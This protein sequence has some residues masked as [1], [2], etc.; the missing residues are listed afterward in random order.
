M[1]EKPFIMLSEPQAM[2]RK[3]V[4]THIVLPAFIGG[5]FL[6]MVS[7]PGVTMLFALS[8]NRDIPSYEEISDPV[9]INRTKDL[10][11]V[12][13]FLARHP[14]PRIHVDR[15]SGFAVSY[16]VMKCEFKKQPCDNNPSTVDPYIALKVRLDDNGYP[17]STVLWCVDG[18]GNAHFD[19]IENDFFW[20]N[21]I[22]EFLDKDMCMFR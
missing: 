15:S 16:S 7:E 20:K 9:L 8:N 12:K 6:F 3:K 14:D 18:K 13:A 4:L 11:E 5:A 17:E 19:K 10:P 1:V 22:I 2:E 21:K